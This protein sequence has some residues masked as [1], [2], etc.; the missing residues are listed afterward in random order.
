MQTR[1]QRRQARPHKAAARRLRSH[2]WACKWDYENASGTVTHSTASPLPLP[3]PQSHLHSPTCALTAGSLEGVRDAVWLTTSSGNIPSLFPRNLLHPS[4]SPPALFRSE[5][6]SAA[7]PAG[8]TRRCIAPRWRRC[9][10]CGSRG[11]R[12]HVRFASPPTAHGS[13]TV[14]LLARQGLGEDRSWDAQERETS[15][16]K[17]SIGNFQSETSNRVKDAN[18][19]ELGLRTVRAVAGV[20]TL[21]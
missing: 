11:R 18:E 9:E 3:T 15:N 13:L 1:Y 8:R 5:A 12:R 14:R 16:R 17:L 2:Q 6:A 4:T 10:G 20:C 19:G 7:A 21:W